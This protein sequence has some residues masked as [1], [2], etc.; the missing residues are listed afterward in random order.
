MEPRVSLTMSRQ[1]E[2]KKNIYCR[3]DPR[4]SGLSHDAIPGTGN[5]LENLRTVHLISIYYI[6][7]IFIFDELGNELFPPR[8]SKTLGSYYQERGQR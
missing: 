1:K 4:A 6:G 8:P 7:F 5:R 2:L 3:R